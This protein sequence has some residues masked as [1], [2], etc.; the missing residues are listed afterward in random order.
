MKGATILAAILSVIMAT[1]IFVSFGSAV[2]L[3]GLWFGVTIIRKHKSI[4]DFFVI[5]PDVMCAGCGFPEHLCGCSTARTIQSLHPGRMTKERSD[6]AFK[7][8]RCMRCNVVFAKCAC[9]ENRKA[10]P[11][12]LHH[13][14]VEGVKLWFVLWAIIILVALLG[15]TNEAKEEYD[16][17]T[18]IQQGSEQ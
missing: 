14:A 2:G 10:K 11:G 13:A 5:D 3:L 8:V 7:T 1:A 17:F 18:I 6:H 4:H 16:Y 15:I 9:V 12:S